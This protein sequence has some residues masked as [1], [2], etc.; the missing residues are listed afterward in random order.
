MVTSQTHNEVRQVLNFFELV[1]SDLKKVLSAQDEAGNRANRATSGLALMITEPIAKIIFPYVKKDKKLS[2]ATPELLGADQQLTLKNINTDNAVERLWAEYFED[3]RYGNYFHFLWNSYRHATVH[4][5][6]TPRIKNV[7]ILK[8]H[9]NDLL[10]GV[11]VD[12]PGHLEIGIGLSQEGLER[13]YFGFQ[14]RDY[15]SD[16]ESALA[17]VEATLKDDAELRTRVCVGWELYGREAR[18]EFSDLPE[19]ERARLTEDLRRVLAIGE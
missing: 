8:N 14:T 7:P 5:F 10:T 12:G 4:L 15:C 18:V 16:L 17:R 13:P 3:P 19:S 1:I 2:L 11:G 9:L 6:T